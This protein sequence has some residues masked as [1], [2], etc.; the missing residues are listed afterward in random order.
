MSGQPAARE[1]QVGMG[2]NADRAS[3]MADQT[4]LLIVFLVQ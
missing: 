3:E 2:N 1:P 4:A